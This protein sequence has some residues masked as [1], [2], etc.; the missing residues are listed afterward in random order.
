MRRERRRR[1]RARSCCAAVNSARKRSPSRTSGGRPGEQHQVLRRADRRS[2][3]CRSGRGRSVGDG[4]DAEAR[5]RVVERDSTRGARR[6]ASSGTRPFQSSSV[7]NSSRVALP[8]AAAAERQRLQAVVALADHLHLRGRRRDAVAAPAHH[9]VEQLPAR[10]RRELEQPLVDRGERDLAAGRRRAC[11]RRCARRSSPAPC[12]AR[13]RPSRSAATRTSQLVRLPA[14]RDLGDAELEGGRPR[15]TSAVGCTSPTRPRTASTETN[16][17]GAYGG[18]DRAPRS[19]GRRPTSGTTRASSTPSR[20]T[21]TSAVAAR[22]GMR[23]C[24]RAV[25]P[26]S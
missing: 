17:F 6:R 18:R 3:R 4:D 19:P 11:R 16:T 15:S 8:P 14:D 2:R 24:R 9:R 10:V 21:V 25:S 23:T 5:Q 13:G 7:S 20:S 12:R 1:A 22:N 26:G